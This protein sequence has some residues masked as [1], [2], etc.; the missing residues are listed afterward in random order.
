MK[1]LVLPILFLMLLAA[2]SAADLSAYPSPFVAGDFFDAQ[3]IIGNNGPATDALAAT[4]IAVSLQQL[5][6]ARITAN[7]EEEFKPNRNSILIGL[8]CQNSAMAAI[9]DTKT[10]D[11]G[12]PDG[13]GYIKVVEKEGYSHLIVSGKIAADTRKAARLLA[14][15]SQF[16][17]S[18][19]EMLVT[20]TL[21]SPKAAALTQ[22]LQPKPQATP[23]E[24]SANNDCAESKWCLSGKC[25]ELGCPSGTKAV[26]HDCV[27]DKKA[28]APKEIAPVAAKND[29]PAAQEKPAEKPAE[30]KGFFVRI[31]SFIKSIF[32]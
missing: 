24:C 6:S 11:L 10:C 19:K 29:T 16:E 20:G 15:Y 9:L 4:E 18:G 12:L 13:A 5:T 31:I 30:K 32:S 25:I 8:P 2:A 27:P 3:V 26:N 22:P 23:A 1:K 14:K 17:L 28:E 21:E 7:T